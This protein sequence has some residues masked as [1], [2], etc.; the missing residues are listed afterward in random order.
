V[1]L[2]FSA[3]LLLR[4]MVGTCRT[5]LDGLPTGFPT[6][7]LR[8]TGV[9]DS[10]GHGG[11]CDALPRLILTQRMFCLDTLWINNLSSSNSHLKNIMYSFYTS[12]YFKHKRALIVM[13]KFFFVNTKLRRILYCKMK[14][15]KE[16]EEQFCN[17][18]RFL[19]VSML[20]ETLCNW[21]MVLKYVR[22]ATLVQ[23]KNI[24]YH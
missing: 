13:C 18:W 24:M 16:N 20:F 23:I 14:K 2:A 5:R 4:Q 15:L 12:H 3:L 11:A 19:C 22:G 8:G 21:K 17:H 10:H 6:A 9:A 7:C 1:S